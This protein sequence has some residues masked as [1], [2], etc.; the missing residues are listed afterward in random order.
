MLPRIY[1]G[2]PREAA[3]SKL[4]SGKAYC[5]HGIVPIVLKVCGLWWVWRKLTIKGYS[6]WKFRFWLEWRM[7]PI[8]I[9]ELAG[10]TYP[11]VTNQGKRSFSG[12]G[13]R[14]RVLLSSVFATAKRKLRS[15][16]IGELQCD[17]LQVECI[18]KQDKNMW[19]L[20]PLSQ[21]P[22]MS[23]R[24]SIRH[25]PKINN[26]DKQKHAWLQTEWT[27]KHR[28]VGTN[29]LFR[30]H[31][32]LSTKWTSGLGKSRLGEMMGKNYPMGYANIM[33]EGK[34]NDWESQRGCMGRFSLGISINFTRRSNA[35]A[36][37]PIQRSPKNHGLG[38]SSKMTWMSSVV[39]HTTSSPSDGEHS[40]WLV[41]KS[42]PRNIYEFAICPYRF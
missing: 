26:G 3:T 5:I 27:L 42:F 34:W 33:H 25:M 2:Y 38:F 4:P 39:V 18:G 21:V 17:T 11:S 15:G 37:L 19:E 10:V 6:M 36:V 32:A 28:L 13:M 35:V 24:Q 31:F 8:H 22:E 41:S 12:V 40:S 9:Q 20:E 23:R 16:K 29:K 7:S 14:I 30:R 1:R